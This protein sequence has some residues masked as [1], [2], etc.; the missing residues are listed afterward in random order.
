MSTKPSNKSLK[1]AAAA[2]AAE[3]AE[4]SPAPPST[5]KGPEKPQ[6][7]TAISDAILAIFTLYAVSTLYRE[8][9]GSMRQSGRGSI[10]GRW[11]LLASLALGI[12]GAAA[13]V[14]SLRF[15]GVRAL[16][17]LHEFL[18]QTAMFLCMPT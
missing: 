3:A 4:A 1:R 11:Q 10:V 15:A 2:A 6:I 5:R 13:A 7:S 16:K 17:N 14:G 9:Q 8:A 18:A 12:A